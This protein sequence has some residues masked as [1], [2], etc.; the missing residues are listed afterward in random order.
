MIRYFPRTGNS[1]SAGARIE[2][3]AI[4]QT[5]D[6]HED[7]ELGYVPKADSILLA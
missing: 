2:R 7:V 6:E 1:D 3:K 5:S 4:E